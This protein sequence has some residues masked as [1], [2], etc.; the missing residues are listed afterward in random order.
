MSQT[1]NAYEFIR[2]IN[3][4][5]T[6]AISGEVDKFLINKFP[7]KVI[8][9]WGPIKKLMKKTRL[10][11]FAKRTFENGIRREI[12]DVM[13]PIDISI[14]KNGGTEDDK[15]AY[16]F[17]K[18]K[19]ESLPNRNFKRSNKMNYL[20][21]LLASLTLIVIMWLGGQ[22]WIFPALAL[23]VIMFLPTIASLGVVNIF[24]RLF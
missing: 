6:K 3:I 9:K 19:W 12:Y 21:V 23:G 16:E 20:N 14:K 17:L 18:Q 24:T 8:A 1:S 22:N 7:F 15:R 13:Q 2:E 10:H 11:P 4:L 5:E